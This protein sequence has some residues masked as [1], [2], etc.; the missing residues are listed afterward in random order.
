MAPHR[1]IDDPTTL[2]RLLDATLLI[3]ADLD[4]PVLLRHVT[5]EAR[6]M[7]GARY[8]ALGVLN[9]ERTALA[10]FITVGLDPD[11]EDRIGQRPTGRG[12]LG[13]VVAS[14]EP[15]RLAVLGSH[16]DSFGFPPGHPPMTSFL[17]V[18]V[19]VRDK[20]YGNLYLT[21]KVG[22]SEF[23][24]ADESLVKALAVSAG[25][26]IEN[27]RLHRMVQDV[28]VYDERER[29]ARDLHDM[30]IQ[31][32]FAL[33]LSLQGIAG[34]AGAADVADRLNRVVAD[35]DNAIRQL[36]AVIFEL[37][38][39][40]EEP[41]VRAG[42]IS[43]LRDLRVVVGFDVRSS[44]DG[45]V[46]SAISDT[47]AE[48]VLMTIREAVTNVGRHAD[49]TEITV[50]LSATDGRCRLVVVDNGRGFDPGE[51]REGGAGLVNLRRRAEKL[52]GRFDV[53]CRS[54]G[55]TTMTWDVPL[56]S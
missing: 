52:D 43:L 31:R 28:A 26:A 34:A 42:V 1:A 38:L 56:A 15:L 2:R 51:T 9:Q 50:R 46:D 37:G 35:V 49:A 44:F 47:I 8:G 25:I 5:E 36:R 32:L 54:T 24:D 19:K 27:A 6:S 20:V 30:V 10:E 40:G 53:H 39:T 14:P 21:D 29:L 45:P 48:H 55:G 16:A 41:G 17:G 7:T 18:P 23:T 11:E 12:V 4:L 13:L 3:E 22:S 33:G